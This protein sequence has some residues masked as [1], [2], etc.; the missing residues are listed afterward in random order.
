M[1]L[2]ANL[3]FPLFLL[4]DD[5]GDVLARMESQASHYGDVSRKIWEFA[6]VGYKENKSADLLKSELRKSG[7]RLEEGV[8]GMPTA[9]TGTWGQGKPVIA[10]LGEYDALPGL[11]QETSPDRKPLLDGGPGHGC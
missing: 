9:F 11:S 4:A 7:F 6:E 5:K 3:L 1:R 2:L 8:A 10:I